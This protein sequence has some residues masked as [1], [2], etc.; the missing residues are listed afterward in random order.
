MQKHYQVKHLEPSLIQF[1]KGFIMKFEEIEKVLHAKTTDII[2]LKTV[3]SLSPLDYF[4]I[5]EY[6]LPL[7]GNIWVNLTARSSTEGYQ[8]LY[9]SM[10]FIDGKYHLWEGQYEE[11]ITNY[12][13][14][15][16]FDNIDKAFQYIIKELQKHANP[17]DLHTVL[18][19][20]V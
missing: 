14:H 2:G 19:Y 12:T 10:T 3:T 13:T 17:K 1:E 15:T 11:Y 5:Y 4:D 16:K 18:E 9:F 20:E 6:K 7:D 8:N